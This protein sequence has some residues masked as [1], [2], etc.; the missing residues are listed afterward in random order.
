MITPK[1]E[2]PYCHHPT[3]FIS[4]SENLIRCTTCDK[5]VEK[6]LLPSVSLP[7]KGK[8]IICTVHGRKPLE[9]ADVNLLAVG[10]PKGQTYFN[11]GWEHEPGLAPSRE[12]VTFTKHNNHSKGRLDGW[13]ERY[14][15]SL[16]DEWEIR[17]DSI[18]AL[19]KV[20]KAVKSNKVVAISCYCAPGKRDICHLSV[21]KDILEDL[22]CSVEEAEQ[23]EYK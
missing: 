21:L 10:K 9:E 6:S 12:L 23:I 15:E 1:P 16:L 19:S 20:V 5:D 14:T 17:G 11:L 7:K 22:G 2:C 8:V 3:V 18:S 13:F 4:S